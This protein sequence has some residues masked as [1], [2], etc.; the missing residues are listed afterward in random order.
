MHSINA[1]FGRSHITEAEY[2]T[3][4]TEYN[5]YY[6]EK[7]NLDI[8][9]K[10]FDAI[11]SDQKNL[12]SFILK[13]HGIYTRYY[14][15]NQLYQKELDFIKVLK[16]DFFFIYN[17]NHIYGASKTDTWYK[18][19]SLSGITRLN[20]DSLTRE[21]NIGFIVPVNINDEFYHNLSIIKRIAGSLPCQELLTK[22]YGEKKILGELEIPIGICM[23]IMETNLSGKSADE[24]APII[25]H[26]KNYNTFIKQFTK[27]YSLNLILEYLPDI[28]LSLCN[29]NRG[30]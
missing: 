8:D 13:K 15:I 2:N 22:I 3:Y 21:K 7:F 1:Y 23:D 27:D 30:L 26:V 4:I 18:V 6:K 20:I 10:D 9:C 29:L 17:E 25:R 11:S 19:D 16:G 14:A 28:I 12:V 24:F 5:A